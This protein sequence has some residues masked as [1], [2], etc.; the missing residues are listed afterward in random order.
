M[1]SRARRMVLLV[2][3]AGVSVESPVASAA[4]AGYK[5]DTY[6]SRVSSPERQLGDEVPGVHDE[7]AP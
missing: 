3:I 4:R 2:I 5:R 6:L 1:G 7:I